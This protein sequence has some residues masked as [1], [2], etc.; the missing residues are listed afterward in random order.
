VGF[1]SCLLDWL[2]SKP[3]IDTLL[4][5]LGVF[6]AVYVALLA[7]P[8]LKALRRYVEATVQ[9][10]GEQL[11]QG[12]ASRRPFLS[13]EVRERLETVNL[14]NFGPGNAFRVTWHFID[15]MLRLPGFSGS[16]APDPIGA[17][18]IQ[19]CVPLI[20]SALG[21]RAAVKLSMLNVGQGIRV[22]YEDSSKK[23]YWSTITRAPEGHTYTDSGAS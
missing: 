23:R 18:G 5:A 13:I 16:P 19:Q 17:M 9:M 11:Q 12:I 3:V 7:L 8:N 6:A 1:V 14:V 21:T 22:E 2:T 15:P 20:F 4:T 10:Q